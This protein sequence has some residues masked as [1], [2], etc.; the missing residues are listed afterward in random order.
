MERSPLRLRAANAAPPPAATYRCVSPSGLLRPPPRQ[1]LR[2]SVPPPPPPPP[3]VAGS[4][5]PALR[6]LACPGP[7]GRV[8]P[9]AG[10]V[11]RTLSCGGLETAPSRVLVRV[12][13]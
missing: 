5:S 9:P 10:R 7:D 8:L 3:G 13:G 4:P 2:G 11:G 6:G 1:V 12:A